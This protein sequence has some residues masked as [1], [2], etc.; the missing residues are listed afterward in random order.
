MSKRPQRIAASKIESYEVEGLE[1]S[2]QQTRSNSLNEGV[3]DNDGDEEPV[4]KK[5][6][7]KK[8]AKPQRLSDVSGGSA[9]LDED[10]ILPWHPQEY[11]EN[12]F[13]LVNQ[14]GL[15]F[16]LKDEIF[17][18]ATK[19]S[20]EQSLITS[21]NNNVLWEKYRARFLETIPEGTEKWLVKH[22]NIPGFFH[23]RW[24]YATF[25]T[26]NPD[27]GETF[28][29]TNPCLIMQ[30]TKWGESPLVCTWDAFPYRWD[31]PPKDALSELPWEAN[32]LPWWKAFESIALDYQKEM[33]TLSKLELVL[34]KQ[35]NEALQAE[36]DE[37]SSTYK[38][39]A[40]PLKLNDGLVVKWYGKIPNIYVLSDPFSEV[41]KKLIFPSYHLE[42][43]LYG[44]GRLKN[45]AELCD[46]SWNMCA[47]LMGLLDVNADYFAWKDIPKIM[48][49]TYW[50][51]SGV[52]SIERIIKM[53]DFEKTS[54]TVIA[55]EIVDDVF[56]YWLD[57]HGNRASL[58]EEDGSPVRQIILVMCRKGLATQSSTA[59]KASPAYERMKAGSTRGFATGRITMAKPEWIGSDGWQRKKEGYTRGLAAG[60]ATMAQSEFQ[61]TESFQRKREGNLNGLA[62]GHATQSSEA[63]KESDG[64]KNR[65]TGMRKHLDKVQQNA[66][67]EMGG[68]M[69]NCH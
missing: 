24:H 38:V 26:K 65:Q 9:R 29:P 45:Q 52:N 60:R 55:K 10:E 15:D 35:N 56:G 34:G 48:N 59:F 19:L 17:K 33:R 2:E 30:K 8:I 1:E 46:L 7:T 27:Y 50:R 4:R 28:D 14:A 18:F 53:R 43:F 39:T 12:F 41:V 47:G 23:I 57:R 20:S 25:T 69:E 21:E 64:Y 54:E 58:E 63:Y 31:K 44:T 13:E 67:T 5:R 40:I 37:L 3:Y 36:L 68:Q 66:E 49:A 22:S 6:D 32:N 61:E 11:V 62:K 51:R 16:R 42:T